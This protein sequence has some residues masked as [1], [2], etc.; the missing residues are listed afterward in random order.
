MA[1]LFRLPHNWR[2]L[3]LLGLALLLA[4]LVGRFVVMRAT[5]ASNVGFE[6]Q[7]AV[8]MVA[9]GLMIFVAAACGVVWAVTREQRDIMGEALPIILVVI[10]LSILLN[11]LLVGDR[12]PGV[13]EIFSQIPL[14]FALFGLGL[15]IGHLLAVALGI[16]RLGRDLKTT[17]E[18]HKYR[19]NPKK[20]AL[21]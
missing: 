18:Y 16:D 7:D 6:M 13:T 2:S 20:A 15:L 8:T 17:E 11:P 19:A 4:N 9:T 14:L 21:K 1:P 12:F 5:E 3:C 10:L